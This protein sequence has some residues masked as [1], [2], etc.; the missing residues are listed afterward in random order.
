MQCGLAQHLPSSGYSRRTLLALRS[1]CVWALVHMPQW[2]VRV[3]VCEGNAS[4]AYRQCLA[5]QAHIHVV[6]AAAAAAVTAVQVQHRQS[7]NA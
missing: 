3:V 1:Y 5:G 6:A 2:S 7:H 4:G